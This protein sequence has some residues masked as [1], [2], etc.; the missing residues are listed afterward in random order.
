[1]VLNMYTTIL[2]ILYQVEQTTEFQVLLGPPTD[3]TDS[4]HV[5]AEF[6]VFTKV[7]TLAERQQVE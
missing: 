3:I 6:M 4:D 2:V 7:L 1:M 5:I